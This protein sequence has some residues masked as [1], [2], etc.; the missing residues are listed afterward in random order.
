MLNV[1]L[2]LLTP[3]LLVFGL[4]HLLTWFD[5][6]RINNRVFWKRVALTAAIAHF[7]LTTGFFIFMYFEFQGNRTYVALGMN[8]ATFLFRHSEFW[9]LTA[10]FDTAP[11]LGLLGLFAVMG[12]T[13]ASGPLLLSMTM[14]MIY[15]VG[16]LQWYYVAGGIG[17]IV[18][19]FWDGLKTG[20]D[21]EEWFQ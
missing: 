16:T 7:L 9:R 14:A 6:L 15:G 17:A 20:D 3:L 1:L 10:I 8:Y 18:E 12:P 19:K 4:Y 13:G 2:A 11:M 5:I 21:D